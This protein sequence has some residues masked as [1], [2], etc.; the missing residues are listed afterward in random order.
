M[1]TY[2]YHCEANG[3]TLEVRHR[4]TD[5]LQ[6]WGEVCVAAGREPGQTPAQTPVE[7]LISG[8]QLASVS[9]GTARSSSMAPLPMAGCCGN[10]AS[11][12]HHG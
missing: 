5:K 3:E 11:C 9:G 1:L 10:P 12:H 4:M 2:Q 7:R 6:T 8:G